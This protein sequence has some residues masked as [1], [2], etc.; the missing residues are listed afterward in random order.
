M[1][2]RIL[3]ACP[4]REQRLDWFD[5][6]AGIFNL[7]DARGQNWREILAERSVD[8]DEVDE[9]LL[10]SRLT[11]T[12][13]AGSIISHIGSRTISPQS[14]V[15]S[16]TLYYERLVGALNGNTALRAL[17]AAKAES[18]GPQ[19]TGQSSFEDLKRKFLM[20]S[21]PLI[22][23]VIALEQFPRDDV[24][25]FYSW[26]EKRVDRISQISAVE[27]GLFYLDIFPELE[28][29]LTRMIRMFPEDGPES[30]AGRLK[31]LSSLIVMVE[32]EVSRRGIA[33]QRPPFWRRLAVI[34]HASIIER[35]VIAASF[36]PTFAEWAM[37]SGEQFYYLQS[38]VDLR[39]EPR[40]LPDFVLSDQ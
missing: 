18:C 7:N 29:I 31:L 12:F 27:R 15:P 34:A 30:S 6:E 8:D 1:L 23:H 26:A 38:F 20:S 37:H 40:W 25:H 5:R 22:T 33:R 35:E 2:S 17:I 4:H 9:L 36:P 28:S 16:D 19:S 39:L 21:Q 13:V 3:V 11:P 10:E 14:L 32:G 24:L